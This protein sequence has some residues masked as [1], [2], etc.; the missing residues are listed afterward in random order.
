MVVQRWYTGVVLLYDSKCCPALA[1][2]LHVGTGLSVSFRLHS[3]G[4][5]FSRSS[6]WRISGSEILSFTSH[7]RFLAGGSDR[8]IQ[9]TL[10][11][12][13]SAVS[14]GER[15]DRAVR[16]VFLQILLLKVAISIRIRVMYL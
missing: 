2:S 16:K 13:L 6:S 15:V 12:V 14:A 10:R 4:C 5:A 11:C 3:G 1:L 9:M 8:L 7:S